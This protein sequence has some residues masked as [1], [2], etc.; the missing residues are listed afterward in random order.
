[1]MTHAL[2]SA[3]LLLHCWLALSYDDERLLWTH[4]ICANVDVVIDGVFYL[5]EYEFASAAYNLVVWGLV[6]CPL[7][8]WGLRQLLRAARN[9]ETVMKD[10]VLHSAI[11]AFTSSL[12]PILYF[13][14]EWAVVCRLLG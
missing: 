11:F 7:G 5:T 2:S 12:M 10:A 1:M 6:L 4:F 9:F 3:S 13:V 14:F 8:A